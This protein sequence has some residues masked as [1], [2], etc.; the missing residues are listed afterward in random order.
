M[1]SK[2][3]SIRFPQAF[4]SW[5]PPASTRRWTPTADTAAAH[6]QHAVRSPT[7]NDRTFS[8]PFTFPKASASSLPH[9]CRRYTGREFWGRGRFSKRS[10]SPPDP[11]SRRVAGNRLVRF[12]RLVRPCSVGAIPCCLAVVTAADRAAATFQRLGTIPVNRRR[13]PS[14]PKRKPARL[15][16]HRA[17]TQFYQEPSHPLSGRGA[18]G[19]RLSQ[20]GGL[21]RSLSSVSPYARP[22]RRGGRRMPSG[23]RAG[24]VFSYTM[25][26]RIR[27][28]RP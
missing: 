20:K 19:R 26:L 27:L 11:L 6:P 16:K 10:G 21:P 17:K 28:M 9:F 13:A 22:S 2:N 8:S 14:P 18:R 7:S 24:A 3:G 1:C 15:P 23:R 12:F 4:P 25:S 5:S